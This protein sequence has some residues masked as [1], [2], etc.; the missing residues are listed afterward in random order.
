MAVPLTDRKCKPCRGGV[1]PLTRV[2]CSTYLTELTEWKL[3][4]E[5]KCISRRYRFGEYRSALA[6]AIIVSDLAEETWH[7]PQLTLSWG[8]CE[9]SLT[10]RKIDG[11]HEFDFVMAA[12]IDELFTR[13][14]DG[15]EDRSS[16]HGSRN[17]SLNR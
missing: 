6:F 13:T 17:K 8:F 9:V 10:T 2:E 16:N 7:H 15:T 12:Q 4:G 11:L 5:G 14:A 3:D 1:A